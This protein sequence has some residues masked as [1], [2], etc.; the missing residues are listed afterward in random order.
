MDCGRLDV[1][2][3]VLGFFEQ[4]LGIPDP[5][6]GLA[7]TRGFVVAQVIVQALD[8]LDALA[9]VQC[10]FFLRLLSQV[11]EILQAHLPTTFI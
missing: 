2:Q 4:V 11:L 9:E 7:G 6:A 8:D 1:R 3:M 10:E 5:A